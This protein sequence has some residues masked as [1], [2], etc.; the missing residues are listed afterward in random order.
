MT[1]Y[2]PPPY[3]GA[4]TFQEMLDHRQRAVDEGREDV[5]KCLQCQTIGFYYPADKAYVEGHCYSEAGIKEF[6]ALS[7][8]CEWCFD[9]MFDPDKLG[10][11]EPFEP[12]TDE[13]LEQLV[14]RIKAELADTDDE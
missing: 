1:D 3:P 8:I 6:A 11:E 14:D 2:P 10:E 9:H 4:I 7:G 12:L 13:Q 5:R